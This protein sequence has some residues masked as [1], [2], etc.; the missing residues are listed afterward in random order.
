MADET[1]APGTGELD[2]QD[3]HDVPDV[4]EPAE[5]TYAEC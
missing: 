5:V 2:A 4:C 1:D 3:S